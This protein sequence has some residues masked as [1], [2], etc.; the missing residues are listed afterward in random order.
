MLID[1]VD[2]KVVVNCIRMIKV[3]QLAIVKRQVFQVAVIRILLNENDVFGAHGF[4][5]AIRNRSLARTGPAANANNQIYRF[6]HRALML[7]NSP[8]KICVLGG[9]CLYSVDFTTETQRTQRKHRELFSN[10]AIEL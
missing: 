10:S 8:C 2:E 3:G 5:D 1:V 7:L 6:V 4:E 9:E